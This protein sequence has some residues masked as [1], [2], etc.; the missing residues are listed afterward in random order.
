MRNEL[1]RIFVDGAGKRTGRARKQCAFAI[2][3]CAD[4]SLQGHRGISLSN[5]SALA[6][7]PRAMCEVNHTCFFATVTSGARPGYPMAASPQFNLDCP[8][9]S[10]R[11]IGHWQPPGDAR[12]LVQF[13]ALRLRAPC[14]HNPKPLSASPRVRAEREVVLRACGIRWLACG[15]FGFPGR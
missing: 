15:I 10:G 9:S 1:L 11:G 4:G 3:Y 12:D 8:C 13:R 6:W 14:G 5:A 2:A 7:L